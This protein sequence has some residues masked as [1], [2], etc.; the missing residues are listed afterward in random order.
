MPRNERRNAHRY[1]L[2]R[3][4]IRLG[5]WEGQQFRTVAARL[6]DLS[7]SG[8]LVQLEE[9]A[10]SPVGVTSWICL[11][12]QSPTHWVQTETVEVCPELP[13]TPRGL[14]LRFLDAFPYESFKM[15]V[16][17]EGFAER[18]PGPGVDES[19]PPCSEED[20]APSTNLVRMTESERNGF[21]LQINAPTAGSSGHDPNVAAPASPHP[22]TLVEAYRRQMETSSKVASLPWLIVFLLGLIVSILLGLLARGQMINLRRLGIVLGLT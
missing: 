22:P 21:F 12:D 2:A 16:W 18:K 7:L 11:A 15:A 1:E 6:R 5:W 20:S 10:A 19:R 9:G 8:A 14:R 4:K 13:A 17:D 3:D